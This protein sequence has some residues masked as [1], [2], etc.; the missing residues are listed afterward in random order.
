MCIIKV[1]V[2]SAIRPTSHDHVIVRI[3]M[4]MLAK[5]MLSLQCS[6][7]IASIININT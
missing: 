7:Y 5:Q 3:W 2:Y 4:S 1:L 6:V